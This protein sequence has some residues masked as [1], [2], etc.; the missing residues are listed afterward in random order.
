MSNV[1]ELAQKVGN[2]L[3]TG[4][5]WLAAF[6]LA[7]FTIAVTYTVAG[8]YIMG[9]TP[10]WAEELPR[11]LLVWCVFLAAAASVYRNTH[12]RADLLG[13]LPLSPRTRRVIESIGEVL[14]LAFFLVMMVAGWG[15]AMKTMGMSTTALE[16]PAGLGYLPLPIGFGLSALLLVIA[17]LGRHQTRQD[18]TE[19]RR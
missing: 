7:G 1:N 6:C 16:L 5:L 18:D 15:L 14:M 17:R 3:S 4:L 10:H 9:V 11:L 8:R 2:A 19:K 13:I 12:L